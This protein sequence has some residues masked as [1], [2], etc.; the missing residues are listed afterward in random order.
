MSVKDSSPAQGVGVRVLYDE[1]QRKST[2]VANGAAYLDGKLRWRL[3]RFF[4]G[5]EKLLYFWG[6]IPCWGVLRSSRGLVFRQGKW[7][8][9]PPCV[10]WALLVFQG[11][12]LGRGVVQELSAELL[13]LMLGESNVGLSLKWVSRRDFSGVKCSADSGRWQ[14]CSGSWHNFPSV[15][16]LYQEEEAEWQSWLMCLPQV[17]G[18]NCKGCGLWILQL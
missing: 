10:G 7:K 18:Q 4:L 5:L 1:V 3:L 16:H 12:S 11:W 8:S 15:R 13:C 9:K 2:A 17:E 6:S 14:I